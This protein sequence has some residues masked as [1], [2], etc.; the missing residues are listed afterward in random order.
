VFFTFG[1]DLRQMVYGFGDSQDDTV[2]SASSVSVLGR[3]SVRTDHLQR[4]IELSIGTGISVCTA[5]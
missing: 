1:S 4:Y 2:I 5:T 3:I